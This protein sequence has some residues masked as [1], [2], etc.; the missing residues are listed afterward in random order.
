MV[1]R[2]FWFTNK[3]TNKHEPIFR[4]FMIFYHIFYLFVH[5]RLF[6]HRRCADNIPVNHETGGLCR[7]T[8]DQVCRFYKTVLTLN[9]LKLAQ[10]I[11]NSI[12]CASIKHAVLKAKDHPNYTL[13]AK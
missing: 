12:I 13:Y 1:L 5:Q 3:Y 11:K 9:L 10:Y 4:S 7:S 8:P 2:L 6:T